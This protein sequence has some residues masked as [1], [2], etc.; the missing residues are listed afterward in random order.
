MPTGAGG[1][2]SGQ[3]TIKKSFASDSAT[4]CAQGSIAGSTGNYYGNRFCLSQCHCI[5]AGIDLHSG[6]I[7]AN[8]EDHHRSVEFIGLL[9]Q[10]DAHY[11]EDAIILSLIHI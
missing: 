9:K 6:H 3:K 2:T 11:P 1:A 5:L 4:R 10:L 8:I 7:F